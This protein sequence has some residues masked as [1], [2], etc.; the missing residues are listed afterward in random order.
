[1]GVAQYND[2]RRRVLMESAEIPRISSDGT[3]E[4]LRDLQ[5]L[6]SASAMLTVE[7]GNKERHLI[8]Q[9]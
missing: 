9:R 7:L 4:I 1:M 2:L 6:R 3:P 8:T 5:K